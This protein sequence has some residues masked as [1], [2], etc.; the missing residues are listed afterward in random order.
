MA[1]FYILSDR[2]WTRISCKYV[3]ACIYTHYVLRVYKVYNKLLL[4]QLLILYYCV[5]YA[6]EKNVYSSL[7]RRR[8]DL[9][10][11]VHSQLRRVFRHVGGRQLVHG[12]QVNRGRQVQ[13]YSRAAG[14]A[15]R[16]RVIAY[17]C[18]AYRSGSGSATDS[19]ERHTL[20][21]SHSYRRTY[22]VAHTTQINLCI[23][24]I[25]VQCNTWLW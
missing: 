19:G 12:R 14:L 11:S 8:F 16:G 15:N 18:C 1:R 3:Y 24:K 23:M 13:W 9:G 20:W 4:S 6:H 22:N 21:L 17:D 10:H 25:N 2:S 7:G 5:L